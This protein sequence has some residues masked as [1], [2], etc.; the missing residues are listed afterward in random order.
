MRAVPTKIPLK[1]GATR[2]AS[3]PVKIADSEMYKQSSLKCL[4]K[5]YTGLQVNF[6]GGQVA[7]IDLR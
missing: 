7:V 3:C 6:K 2:S 1:Y 5:V 4:A